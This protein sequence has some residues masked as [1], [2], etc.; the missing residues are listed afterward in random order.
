MISRPAAVRLTIGE[1]A[2]AAGMTVRN[3][4]NHQSRGL[5]PPPVLEARTG[6]Y[7]T[8]HLDRLRL[9]QSMQADGFN[10]EAI[11]RV[12][13]G[14]ELRRAAT[15]P[16][17]APAVLTEAELEARFGSLDL[18]ALAEAE[19]LGVLVRLGDGRFEAPSPALLSA[20][21]EAVERGVGLAAALR[22]V[23]QVKASCETM[24]R[25]FVGV[26]TEELWR[27]SLEEAEAVAAVEELRPVAART[28]LALFEQA[29]A[30]EAGRAI[31]RSG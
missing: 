10:L 27:P 26:F 18:T 4:R 15:V 2:D 8:Q 30:D 20:A 22:A 6:Y 13:S 21:E 19:R 28:V 24:A 25:A 17:E 11:R 29:M 9:I 23:E 3:I 7:G 12:L 5:L 14:S 31:E 16:A 1:L